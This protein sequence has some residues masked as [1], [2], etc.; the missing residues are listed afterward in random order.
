MSTSYFSK[1]C[2]VKP[3][4]SQAVTRTCG[5]CP[6]YDALRAR[7]LRRQRQRDVVEGDALKHRRPVHI[8]NTVN[9][10]ASDATQPYIK[11]SGRTVHTNTK[12]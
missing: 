5:V 3:I 6:L 2:Q 4:Y 1:I 7:Q 10:Q 8:Q 9:C 11:L 12:T